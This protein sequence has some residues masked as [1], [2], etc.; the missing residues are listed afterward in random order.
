MPLQ[1]RDLADLNLPLTASSGQPMMVGVDLIDEDPAQPRTEFDPV[2][3]KELASTIADCGVRQ[4][5]S[6]RAHPQV[7]G[8]YM[9]NFGA[10]RLRAARLAGRIEIPAFLSEAGDSYEQ[11]IENE[12]R[13]ALTPMELAL[14]V[15]RRMRAGESLAE[16]ARHLGKSRG[17]LT[18][19]S[20]L[21]DAPEWLVELYRSGKC[22]GVRELYELRRRH[23][24]NP[25]TV[26]P[27]AE[28]RQSISRTDL[29]ALKAESPAAN[30]AQAS[31][32]GGDD[33]GERERSVH[34]APR[35]AGV[36]AIEVGAVKG[37]RRGLIEADHRNSVVMIDL[38]A[39]PEEEGTIYIRTAGDER[40]LVRAAELR[41]LRV[42]LG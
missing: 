32:L 42:V 31:N 36:R 19:V 34:A 41:L 30:S 17:Y 8:R 24:A 1:L 37:A 23:E 29:T 28:R 14:F 35:A 4:P 10:R 39:I 33:A 27:W 11:V 13:E 6:V 21:I 2:P 12:Q 5:V 38:S 20:A 15:Q 26:E 40:R 3:L 22:R 16:I 9:L 7:P 18:L 25:G